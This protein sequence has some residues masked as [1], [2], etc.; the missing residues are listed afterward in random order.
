[1]L[2]DCNHGQ[3]QCCAED[4][5]WEAGWFLYNLLP[6]ASSEILIL[7]EHIEGSDSVQVSLKDKYKSRH[8]GIRSKSHSYFTFYL[9][10]C[11][12]EWNRWSYGLGSWAAN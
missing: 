3:D 1:M 5:H 8:N 7:V 4:E 12:V 6:K 9:N 11:S 10:M 2:M